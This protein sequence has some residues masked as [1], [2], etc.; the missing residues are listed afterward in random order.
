MIKYLFEENKSIKD[1]MEKEISNLKNKH[2]SEIKMLKN[3]LS[4]MKE[5]N[6]NKELNYNKEISN[7]K[8]ENKK[9]WD[10]INQFKRIVNLNLMEKV[11]SNSQIIQSI[12]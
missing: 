3:E 6:V 1:H 4:N 2:E 5:N 10:E 9:L 8:E 7:M 11:N 12:N